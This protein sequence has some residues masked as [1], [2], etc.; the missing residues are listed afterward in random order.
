MNARLAIALLS[1]A[2]AAW[3][4]GARA[5]T[6]APPETSADQP[7]LL[8]SAAGVTLVAS[9]F[10]GGGAPLES[11]DYSCV[12]TVGQS[13]P[14]GVA[15]GSQ[16]TLYSGFWGLWRGDPYFTPVP[17]AA[18]AA[19]RLF[20]SRPNPFN[21]STAIDFETAEACF[22]R[23]TI[24]DVRGHV[25]RRLVAEPRAAGRHTALWNGRDD[26]GRPVASGLYICTLET[27]GQR[28]AGKIAMIK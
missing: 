28:A 24:H 17:D 23:L 25:V 4:A 1:W 14:V 9:V 6:A 5:V 11:D 3:P 21:P 8:P 2:L 26:A 22:V 16:L 10:G 19:T 18:V 27:P 13:S 15:V 12:G 20:P 7:A